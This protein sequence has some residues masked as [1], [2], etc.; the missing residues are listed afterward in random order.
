MLSL[1]KINIENLK[2]A[3]LIF[4]EKGRTQNCNDSTHYSIEKAKKESTCTNQGSGVQ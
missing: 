3:Q 4:L 2:I 1:A